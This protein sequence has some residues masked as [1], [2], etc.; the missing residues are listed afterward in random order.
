MNIYEL[1]VIAIGERVVIDK[2]D[3]S[4]C[5]DR[6]EDCWQEATFVVAARNV[7]AAVKLIFQEYESLNRNYTNTC[8]SIWYNPIPVSVDMD[9][10][11]TSEII[12]CHFR[13][14]IKGNGVAD[15]PPRY[16]IELK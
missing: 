9:D 10:D 3:L 14:P 6:T 15:A 4:G 1:E 16:S 2:G 11:E 7:K 8:D 5:S 13:E 12:S